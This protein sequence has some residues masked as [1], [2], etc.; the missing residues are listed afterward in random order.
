MGPQ[1]EIAGVDRAVTNRS[2]AEG[3]RTARLVMVLSSISP[4]FI[5]WATR[6]IKLIPNCYFLAFCGFMLSHRISFFGYVSRR[7]RD[8]RNDG[9][10]ASVLLKTIGI[11]S[12]CT[13]LLCSY[14]CMLWSSTLGVT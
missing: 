14:R 13:S 8:F 9:S 2:H 3:L 10:S 1:A 5:F 11:I 7:R 12:W 4:L 6:G